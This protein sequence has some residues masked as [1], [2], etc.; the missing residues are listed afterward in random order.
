VE[1]AFFVN[2]ELTDEEWTLLNY[3]TGLNEFKE[4]HGIGVTA[5]ATMFGIEGNPTNSKLSLINLGIAIWP[6]SQLLKKE[7]IALKR[8]KEE[9]IAYFTTCMTDEGW[10]LLNYK[11]IKKEFKEKHSIGVTAL[12]TMFG[13]EG[14]PTNSKLSLINL[15]IAIWPNSQ[16]LKQQQ[17]KFLKKN[18]LS[19]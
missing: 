1:G 17:L 2:T 12:A 6:N 7:L 19:S 14:N 11:T 15:G 16:L 9:W 18:E 5:L 10:G 8:T 3:K 4:K 13:I